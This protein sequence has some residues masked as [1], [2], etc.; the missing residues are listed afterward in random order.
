MSKDD[1]IGL[2][3]EPHR[4]HDSESVGERRMNSACSHVTPYIFRGSDDGEVSMDT[5]EGNAPKISR[6]SVTL[7]CCDSGELHSFRQKFKNRCGH[8]ILHGHGEKVAE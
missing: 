6:N 8:G 2:I 1:E 4:Q 7:L 5:S 3:F